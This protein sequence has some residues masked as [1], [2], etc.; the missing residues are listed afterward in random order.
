MD[1]KP[2]GGFPPHI[3]MR[4]I[5]CGVAGLIL[6]WVAPVIAQP[7]IPSR[8]DLPRRFGPAANAQPAR[9]PWDNDL[10]IARSEDGLV[11]AK[12][13][14]FVE[15]AGVPN[16]IQDAK[17]RLVVAFQWFPADAPDAFDHVAICT[18]DD[19]GKSWSKPAP[20]QLKNLPEGYHHPFDPTL[21]LLDDGR[22]RLFYTSHHPGRRM[23]AIYSAISA[24]GLN[25][26]FEAGMRLGVDNQMVI[27]CAAARNGKTWHLFSPVQPTANQ[28][29]QAPGSAYH[30][31]S[32][33]GLNFKRIEDISIP[34]DTDSHRN[35]LGCAL[36]LAD[37]K[38]RFYGTG[39]G[40]VWSATSPDGIKWT[41]DPTTRGGGADPGIA[42]TGQGGFILIS[43]GPPRADAGQRPPG[44]PPK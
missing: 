11:F 16:V 35:W 24:D 19:A 34:G 9:G 33:D 43:T 31:I 1:T 15:R 4:W 44:Q 18:S 23:P 25:F 26:E 3:N 10:L 37:G 12:G 39:R 14:V 22:V 36:P 40:G 27:D 28:P 2:R 5:I 7:G 29:N 8:P 38:I 6:L 20:I 30:A 13:S 32:D 21:V 42:A 17:G 41:P